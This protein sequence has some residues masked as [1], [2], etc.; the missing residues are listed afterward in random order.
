V[1]K[2][3][4]QKVPVRNTGPSPAMGGLQIPRWLGSDPLSAWWLGH[5]PPWSFGF[6]SQTRGTRENRRTLC[7][8]TGFLTGPISLMVVLIAHVLH[9]P[10]PPREQLCNRSCNTPT[11][12]S[13][14]QCAWSLGL[15][16]IQNGTKILREVL[17]PECAHPTTRNENQLPV[18]RDQK[19]SENETVA[20]MRRRH[21]GG[22]AGVSAGERR[23]GDRERRRL[24]L[25]SRSVISRSTAHDETRRRH[26]CYCS[27]E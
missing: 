6:D 15:L 7:K 27:N 2:Y 5:Q 8:S 9:S 3:K 18:A 16:T 13:V 26:L 19:V 11:V 4:V 17:C 24:Y 25:Y 23:K 1:L 14:S 12:F 10:P 22:R 21:T 20:P